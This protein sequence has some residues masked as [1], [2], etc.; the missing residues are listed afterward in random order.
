MFC[1]RLWCNDAIIADVDYG[2][3]AVDSFDPLTGCAIFEDNL[4]PGG[5][6]AITPAK[7]GDDLNGVNTLDLIRISQHILGLVPLGSPYAMIAADANKSNSITTFDMVEIKKLIQGIYTELP[8]NTS[9]RFLDANF[10]FPN[11]SNPFQ[12]AWPDTFTYTVQD[13]FRYFNIFGIKM[14][15]VDCSA[16]PGFGSSPGVEDR[17]TATLNLPDATL[18]P[19]ETVE[20]PI[21]PAAATQWLG[22]QA[23][24]RFDP[25]LLE[26]ESVAPGNLP[27][28]DASSFALPQPGTLNVVWFNT[29]PQSVSPEENL[30][31]LRLKARAPLRLS[32]TIF[33][34]N[35][36]FES[37]SY[38][39]EEATQKLQL[40][41]IERSEAAGA[42][43][44][45]APEPNPTAGSAAIPVRLVQVETVMLELNDLSGKRLWFNQITLNSGTHL[46]E[47][48][49][50][51]L[52]QPGMYVWR[53]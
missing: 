38:T 24:L 43:T 50:V 1:T 23:G 41:F 48:P 4:P 12:G 37:E 26:I 31:S 34:A 2:F 3:G 45:F 46:L 17:I 40:Q 7:D 20:I 53:I 5:N 9:W 47:I 22:L 51:A 13:S 14:G 19:G 10:I 32:E 44:L 11:P 30:F 36:K 18:L 35:E 8:N 29:A 28:M 39:A 25:D 52:S 42:T 27:D 16:Y 15:D 33:L 49:A 21:R 6:Y